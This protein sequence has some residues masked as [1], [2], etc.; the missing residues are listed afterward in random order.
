MCENSEYNS[1]V[2]IRDKQPDKKY[3]LGFHLDKFFIHMTCFWV[4]KFQK[5]R[6]CQTFYIVT[7]F[8][9]KYFF[10]FLVQKNGLKNDDGN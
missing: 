8:T 6:T 5:M 3:K 10:S 9:S 7:L 2:A 4:F 1:Y